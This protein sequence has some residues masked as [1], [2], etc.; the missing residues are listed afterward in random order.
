MWKNEICQIAN[1]NDVGDTY[2]DPSVQKS[3]TSS[4]KRAIRNRFKP[5]RPHM[6]GHHHGSP[7]KHTP[8]TVQQRGTSSKASAAAESRPCLERTSAP[9]QVDGRAA[10]HDSYFQRLSSSLKDPFRSEEK[11]SMSLC[12]IVDGSSY[13]E[14]HRDMESCDIAE[15]R[16]MSGGFSPTS[17]S[18]KATV[19]TD[20]DVI[21]QS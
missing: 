5:I 3:P 17:S 12:D 11:E 9:T 2:A 18:R 20:D 8:T 21:Q 14:E 4:Q 7:S 13:N 6:D 15:W 1:S 10:T 19:F 16:S